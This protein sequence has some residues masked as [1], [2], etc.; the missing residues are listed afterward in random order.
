[1]SRTISISLTRQE[2]FIRL[3][4]D[5]KEI[6]E[7]R[8]SCEI[9]CVP[10]VIALDGF[11]YRT[12]G[13]RVLCLDGVA[14]GRRMLRIAEGSAIRVHHLTALVDRSDQGQVCVAIALAMARSLNKD[15]TALLEYTE[16]WIEI[17]SGD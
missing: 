3:S 4:L 7:R 15:D 11:R 1:M 12:E 5:A 9:A 16:G 8:I 13:A 14:L 6:P 10:E 2:Q 17:E